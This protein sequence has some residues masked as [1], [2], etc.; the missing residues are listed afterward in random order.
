ME[1]PVSGKSLAKELLITWLISSVLTIIT[2]AIVFSA[3]S[4]GLEGGQGLIIMDIAAIFW[5][6]SL[7]LLASTVFINTKPILRENKHYTFASYYVLPLLAS[8]S[9]VLNIHD[10]DVW[11]SFLSMSIPFFIVHSFFF[12]RRVGVITWN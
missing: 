11:P 3:E 8:V 7:T 10:D 6:L 4:Q 12:L 2:L 5:N 1:N 9:I